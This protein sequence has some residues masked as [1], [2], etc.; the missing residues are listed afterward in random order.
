VAINAFDDEPALR[1]L[2]DARGRIVPLPARG[3]LLSEKLAELLEVRPGRLL[4]VEVREGTRPHLRIPIAGTVDDLFGLQIYARRRYLEEALGE[5][6]LVSM[7]SLRLD[8]LPSAAT[9]ARL[10]DAPSVAS[11]MRPRDVVRGFREQTG[12]IQTVFAAIITIF[13]VAIAMGVVYNN[14]RVVLSMRSRELASLRVLGFSRRELA[15]I[16]IGELSVH[17]LVALPIGLYLGRIFSEGMAAGVDPE[18]YRFRPIISSASDAF[19]V[20]GMLAA[21][22][23]SAWIVRRQL[24]R[25]DVIGVLKTRE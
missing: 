24:A 22:A 15:T 16:L 7:A 17:V 13:A 20:V 5:P 8:P 21:A 10:R 4:D 23:A 19:A 18:T 6:P 3:F 2:L 12:Q 11:V 9:L 14:A 1:R 25:L